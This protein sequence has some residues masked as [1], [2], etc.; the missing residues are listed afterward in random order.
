MPV[1]LRGKRATS[2]AQYHSATARA[3][4]VLGVQWT[5]DRRRTA[6]RR[7]SASALAA[8]AR[9]WRPRPLQLGRPRQPPAARRADSIRR[10]SGRPTRAADGTADGTA[11]WPAHQLTPR[12]RG[13]LA[14]QPSAIVGPID[15]IILWRI[16][17]DGLA[18][19]GGRRPEYIE[20]DE[21]AV[22]GRAGL[23]AVHAIGPNWPELRIRRQR[24][25]QPRGADVAPAPL[26]GC[27]RP[28]LARQHL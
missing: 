25:G 3:A 24:L 18:K 6:W 8:H 28:D 5:S 9:A 23:G 17:A 10:L 26:A 7:V 4:D 27:A 19:L 12:R 15:A 22:H 13:W 14:L 20:S 21:L 1:R 11:D 2:H 16:V